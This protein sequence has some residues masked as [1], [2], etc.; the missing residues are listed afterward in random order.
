[1]WRILSLQYEICVI[2]HTGL[3]IIPIHFQTGNTRVPGQQENQ[4]GIQGNAK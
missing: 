3:Y 1:M 4:K 2:R